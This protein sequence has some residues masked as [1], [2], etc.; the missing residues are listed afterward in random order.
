MTNEEQRKLQKAINGSV[1]GL[2]SQDWRKAATLEPG[3]SCSW[4]VYGEGDEPTICC[5]VGWLIPEDRIPQN[6]RQRMLAGFSG[7]GVTIALRTGAIST[8]IY[9]KRGRDVYRFAIENLLQEIQGAHDF[10]S[11]A[12]NMRSRMII[13][14]KRHS[15]VWP[16]DV[17]RERKLP[18]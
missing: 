5:G 8:E 3:W 16:E 4:R 10:A 13:V 2:D 1:R 18:R 14:V 7:G 12:A 17:D 9:D 11:S 15:L 6:I